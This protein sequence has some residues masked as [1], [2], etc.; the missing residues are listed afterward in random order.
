MRIELIV[1]RREDFTARHASLT[2]ER[3]NTLG[4][5]S[6]RDELRKRYTKILGLD[7]HSK[8]ASARRRET[9]RRGGVPNGMG[10]RPS[11]A[12]Q[13]FRGTLR[14]SNGAGI[15]DQ[16]TATDWLSPCQFGAFHFQGDVSLGE[17]QSGGQIKG[18]QGLFMFDSRIDVGSSR[19]GQVLL[20]LQHVVRG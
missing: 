12:R 6:R 7:S 20:K 4:T 10:T 13:M 17:Q 1:A 3:Q 2:L 8:E 18:Q 9:R 14:V 16:R 5:L 19:V 11:G 15:R